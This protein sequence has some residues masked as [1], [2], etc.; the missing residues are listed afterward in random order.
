MRVK[1]SAVTAF[2]ERCRIGHLATADRS[3]RPHV[4]PVCFALVGEA[5]YFIVDEK[6]KTPG[7]TLARMKNIAE[8]PEVAL[9]VDH[10]DEDWSRLEYVMIRGRAEMV[11]DPVEFA[12]ALERLRERY[13]QYRR[14]RLEHGRN[15]LVRI[16]PERL[17][18]WA[19]T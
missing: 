6:P 7:K 5:V 2:L 15:P 16:T 13:P 17:H 11:S 9:V 14:M 4:I 1:L 18:H 10:Y 3:A 19:A 8:N 12:R